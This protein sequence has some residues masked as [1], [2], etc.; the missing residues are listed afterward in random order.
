MLFRT[1]HRLPANSWVHHLSKPWMELGYP[2]RAP[3]WVGERGLGVNLRLQGQ[4]SKLHWESTS[5]RKPEASRCLVTTPPLHSNEKSGSPNQALVCT[6][7]DVGPP[8]QVGRRALQAPGAPGRSRFAA[9]AASCVLTPAAR[10][11]PALTRLRPPLGFTCD[12]DCNAPP[13]TPRLQLPGVGLGPAHAH[14]AGPEAVS[15]TARAPSHVRM[16][17]S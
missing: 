1:S 15:G 11:G 16:R 4:T 3:R 17:I 13:T 9:A 14:E 6:L 10:S 8:P 12:L 2:Q 7:A 5:P